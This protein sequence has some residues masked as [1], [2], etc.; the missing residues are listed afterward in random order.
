MTATDKPG[1]HV[2]I[3]VGR[4]ASGQ[5]A[6][7]NENTQIQT[8]A[9]PPPTQQDLVDLQALV[10]ALKDRIVAEA[11]PA[12]RECALERVG[13]LEQ[14]VTAEK[15]EVGAVRNVL[16]WFRKRLPALAGSV[17]GLLVNPILGKVVE[18]A[19]EMAADEFRRRVGVED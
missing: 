17:V 9:G 4:D 10:Q 14:A 1:P 19:G 2:S 3:S 7:G 18:A 11:D 6:V 15:P 8:N 13:E 16:T 12:D 5:I